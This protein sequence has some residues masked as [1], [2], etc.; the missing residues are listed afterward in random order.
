MFFFDRLAI[1]KTMYLTSD[2]SKKNE[3]YMYNFDLLARK[4]LALEDYNF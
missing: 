2:K 3:D 1:S 4:S